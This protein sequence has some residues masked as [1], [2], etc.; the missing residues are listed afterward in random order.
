[1]PTFWSATNNVVVKKLKSVFKTQA[2]ISTLSLFRR[3]SFYKQ[4]AGLEFNFKVLQT[5]VCSTISK[6]T[7][8]QMF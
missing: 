6:V 3:G 1:M 5:F 8:S 4:K 7:L 2:S